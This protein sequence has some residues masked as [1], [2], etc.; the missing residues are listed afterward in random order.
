MTARRAA[1]LDRDGTLIAD[2]HYLADPDRVRLVDG[3]SAAV[4]RLNDAGVSVVVVTNQSGIARGLLSEDEYLAVERRVAE[5][6]AAAGARI[7]ATYHCPHHPDFTGPCACRKPGT[8]LYERAIA[9]LHLD[10]RESLFAGDRWRDIAAGIALAGRAILVRGPDTPAVDLEI[11]QRDAEVVDNL[12][13]AV[14]RFLHGM[15]P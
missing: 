8:L 9:D 14:D 12:A 13:E 4:R 1:F 2:E 10:T 15:R 3:S 5:R 11:A 7:D 6:F